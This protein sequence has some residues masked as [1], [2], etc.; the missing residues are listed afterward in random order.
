MSS[1]GAPA[2]PARGTIR[3]LALG[4]GFAF[5]SMSCATTQEDFELGHWDAKNKGP[6]P[7]Y[8]GKVVEILEPEMLP[9][10]G[11]YYIYRAPDNGTQILD[12][13]NKLRRLYALGFDISAAWYRRPLSGCNKPGTDAVTKTMYREF[14]L[15]LLN[16]RTDSATKYNFYEIARPKSLS[17]PYRVFI[18]SPR[19]E[20]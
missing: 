18:Y 2:I 4:L 17:C 13:P 7:T 12:V 20:S 16:K 6:I 14:L 15:L 11:T 1:L 8:S 10:S 19:F 9:D 3:L 5:V